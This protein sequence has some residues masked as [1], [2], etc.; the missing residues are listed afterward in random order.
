[1]F[2]SNLGVILVLNWYFFYLCN[3]VPKLYVANMHVSYY[4]I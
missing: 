2:L 4:L 3:D 1:M